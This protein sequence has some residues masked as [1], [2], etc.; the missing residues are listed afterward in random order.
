MALEI[1]M[2]MKPKQEISV[3][4]LKKHFEKVFHPFI[5]HNIASS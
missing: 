5:N 4:L 2:K 1:E 3:W